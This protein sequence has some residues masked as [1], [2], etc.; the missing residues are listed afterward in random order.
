MYFEK[1]SNGVTQ[2]EGGPADREEKN[3]KNV[4][5]STIFLFL[6]HYGTRLG[7]F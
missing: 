2:S 1:I 5:Y 7:M 6:E 4:D 3:Y